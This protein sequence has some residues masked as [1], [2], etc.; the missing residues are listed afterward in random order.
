MAD[1]TRT[2]TGEPSGTRR[3]FDLGPSIGSPQALARALTD[4]WIDGSKAFLNGG[5][6]R[7]IRERLGDAELADFAREQAQGNGSSADARMFRLILRLDPK[8]EAQY[9]G[10]EVSEAGLTGL[11]AEQDGPFPTQ[12]SSGAL[13]TM[14]T[15]R[16]LT[17][18]A[19][20]SGADRFRELDDR[21]HQEFTT[22]QEHVERAQETGAGDLF[23]A[24]AWRA[25]ARILLGLLDTKAAEGI[26]ERAREAAT[27]GAAGNRWMKGLSPDD[28][29]IGTVMATVDIALPASTG[30]DPL[31]IQHKA[32]AKA[33]RRRILPIAISVVILGLVAWGILA[34]NNSGGTSGAGGAT[35]TGPAVSAQPSQIDAATAPVRGTGVTLKAIDLLEKPDPGANVLQHVDQG[36]VIEIVG[37]GEGYILIRVKEDPTVNGYALKAD[38]RQ[39]CA[40]SCNISAPSP[41]AS[42]GPSP[43]ASG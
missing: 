8:I 43:S 6:E 38:L 18:Y 41:A 29:S 11:A 19:K 16:I 32:Q 1:E 10:Y 40:F 31:I 7:F 25:R 26:R 39:V 28:P 36:V 21:W 17:M 30:V 4:H 42:G 12:D 9:M 27:G 22:W 14:Y 3:G 20:A 33:R 23:A 35:P 2:E 37:N 24:L 5:V 13:R 15:D 34:V